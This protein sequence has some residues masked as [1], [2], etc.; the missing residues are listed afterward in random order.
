MSIM[1]ESLLHNYDGSWLLEYDSSDERTDYSSWEKSLYSSYGKTEPRKTCQLSRGKLWYIQAD[2]C[3]YSQTVFSISIVLT[4]SYLWQC[5][6]FI[7]VSCAQTALLDS[8]EYLAPV[9]TP[10]EAMLAFS[11]YRTTHQIHTSLAY[12]LFLILWYVHWICSIFFV[13]LLFH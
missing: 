5:D 13:F 2:A 12:K 7:Y 6:I 8:K 1:M 11:R 9:I 3:Q 4:E 10:F